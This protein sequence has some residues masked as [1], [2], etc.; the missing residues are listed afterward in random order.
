[1]SRLQRQQVVARASTQIGSVPSDPLKRMRPPSSA[2]MK[3]GRGPLQEARR[4]WAN[5]S[6]VGNSLI[7]P[8]CQHALAWNP[9]DHGDRSDRFGHL[10]GWLQLAGLRLDLELDD[11][12]A[13]LIRDI[14]PL[15]ARVDREV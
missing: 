8:E 10:S 6:R 13:L 4:C 12:V 9:E 14:Q 15:A 3:S 5:V 7:D 11:R 1:M 2:A